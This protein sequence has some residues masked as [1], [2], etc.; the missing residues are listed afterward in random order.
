MGRVVAVLPVEQTVVHVVVNAL[1]KEIVLFLS[2]VFKELPF[3][4]LP[5]L[6]VLLDCK[7]FRLGVPILLFRLV[8][9]VV[10]RVVQL[11]FLAG[12]W[13]RANS[14]QV[15]KEVLD[16]IVFAWLLWLQPSHSK[17]ILVEVPYLPLGEDTN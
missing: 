14:E 15:N 1:P 11:P 16:I 4:V 6:R 2:K 9:D 10:N 5:Q 3:L 13:I 7:P 8:D 17:H 12:Y